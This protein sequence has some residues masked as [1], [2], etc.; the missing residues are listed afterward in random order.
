MYWNHYIHNLLCRTLQKYRRVRV[1][2]TKNSICL[3]DP[4]GAQEHL[5]SPHNIIHNCIYCLPLTCLFL[6]RCKY[7]YSRIIIL[8]ELSVQVLSLLLEGISFLYLECP[9][10]SHLLI[11][12]LDAHG[13]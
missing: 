1:G 2:F 6:L 7:T 9:A 12:A 4:T 11:N 8:H 5:Q 3:V 13:L 10:S